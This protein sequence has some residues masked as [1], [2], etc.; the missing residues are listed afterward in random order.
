MTKGA[1]SSGAGLTMAFKLLLTAQRTWRRLDAHELLPLLRAGCV[2]KDG[3][4]VERE[5]QTS[6]KNEKKTGKVA[7]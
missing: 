3:R 5:A 4:Q 6:E 7:A 2:F 1:G